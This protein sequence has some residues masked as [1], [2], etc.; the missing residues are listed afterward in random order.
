MLIIGVAPARLHL[1][2][3]PVTVIE[4]FYFFLW[5]RMREVLLP[6]TGPWRA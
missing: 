3:N 4:M 6:A 1:S 5:F 2:D